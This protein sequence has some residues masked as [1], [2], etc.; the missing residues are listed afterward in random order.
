MIENNMQS[1]CNK[2]NAMYRCIF[3]FV[4]L[5]RLLEM[6]GG[7]ENVRKD[8]TPWVSPNLV[9]GICQKSFFYDFPIFWEATSS[10]ITFEIVPDFFENVADFQ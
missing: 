2:K 4:P 3:Y 6:F 10:T 8:S 7:L 9:M 5:Q 1:I